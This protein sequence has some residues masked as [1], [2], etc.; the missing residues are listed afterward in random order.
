MRRGRLITF[1][2]IEGCGKST[3][4]GLLAAHLRERG[5]RVVTTREPGGTPLGERVRDLLLDP[6]L[7][8]VAVGELFL[9]EAARSQV[10]SEIIA[11]AL[12][13]GEY[14]LSDRFADS[15]VAYQAGARGIDRTAV[16]SL[17]AVACAGVVPN[18]TVVLDLDVELALE[19]ARRRPTTTSDNRRFEDEA[20]HFHTAVAAAYREL[21]RREPSRVVL[22]D[23]AGAPEEVFAR[24]LAAVSDLLP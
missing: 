3:Q 14:V 19:R 1:E 17:N 21:A 7:S 20:L 5:I 18:R 23:A 24:V 16:E 11:P 15:S 13:A 9:L 22:V 8:P 2:G 12:A 4:V 6:R 10:V